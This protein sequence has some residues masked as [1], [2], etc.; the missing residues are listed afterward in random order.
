MQIAREFEFRS[1]KFTGGEPILRPDIL[2]IIRSVPEGMECSLTTNGTLLAGCAS[3]LKDAGLSR[4]NISLDSLDRETYHR[5]TGK[6][7]LNDVLEG[8]DA[9][10]EAGL[11]PVKLNMVVLKGINEGE[12]ENFI[13]F[14]SGNRNLVLQLIELMEMKGVHLPQRPQWA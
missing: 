14:V 2:E 13:Q 1:V 12:V 3:D 7:C 6:D 10:I 9:A 5:I 4:V 8:I 11:T